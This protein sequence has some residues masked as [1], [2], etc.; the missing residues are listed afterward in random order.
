[1]SSTEHLL[2]VEIEREFDKLD[3]LE[4][5]TDQYRTAVDG[6]TK[7]LQEARERDKFAIEFDNQKETQ[8]K[9][10]ALR[11]KQMKDEQIDRWVKNGLT[12]AGIIIP[13][14]VTVWGT[15]KS[16]RFE[17]TGTITT[18]MGRGFINKLLPKK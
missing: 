8:K 2:D 4:V 12:A 15:I 7:L 6:L 3:K 11:T 17:E 10:E 1:M 9:E 18:I 16:I 13:T 14:I 5:G